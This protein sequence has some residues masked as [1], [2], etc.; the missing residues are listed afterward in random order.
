[1]LFIGLVA[2]SMGILNTL[3]HFAAP[4]LSPVLFNISI[5]VCAAILAPIFDVP[6]YAVVIGVL[7][8]G[9]LQLILQLPFLKAG[10]CC[11][12]AELQLQRP[13]HKKALP[14]HGPGDPR[15]RRISVKYLRYYKVRLIAWP[16][17]VSLISITPQG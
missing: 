3:R 8:G 5:I 10:G 12:Y 2:M 14:P 4:A 17:G 13:G 11:R 16:R 9:V 1:M 6:V 7:I 15:C